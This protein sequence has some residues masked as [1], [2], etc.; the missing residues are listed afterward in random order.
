MAHGVRLLTDAGIETA[1]QEAVWILESVLSL[2]PLE[3]RLHP[4][5]SLPP[6]DRDRILALLERRSAREPLQYLLGTQEFF[7]RSFHVTSAV[8]IPRPETELL[9]HEV[10]RR[11]PVGRTCLIADIGTGSGC[12]AVTLALQLPQCGILA[13]DRSSDALAVAKQNAVRHGVSDR[14]RWFQGDLFDPFHGL[15]LEGRVSVVVANP[16]YIP[17]GELDRLQPEVRRYE[18]RLALAGG[19]DGVDVHRN[20]TVQARNYLEA[21]GILVMEVGI[22]QADLVVEELARAGGYSPGCVTKDE[23]GIGRMVT[24][25]RL[26]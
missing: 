10:L 24:A 18:P 1:A 2:R 13:V 26:R 5:R 3:L 6:V 7:G 20:I 17:D 14:I 16:P 15:D 11:A 22:G 12:L 23:A 4:E 19:P 9:I 21:G 8:L 25:V